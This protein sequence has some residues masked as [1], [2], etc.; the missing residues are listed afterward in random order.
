MVKYYGVS[1]DLFYFTCAYFEAVVQKY[2]TRC[3]L[4][5]ML[6]AKALQSAGIFVELLKIIIF[7]LIW[8]LNHTPDSNI[9]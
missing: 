7:F 5:W 2:G 8:S 9:L 4:F 3:S 1:N 6:Q